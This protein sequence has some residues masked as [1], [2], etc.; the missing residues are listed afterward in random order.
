MG[1][2]E[3]RVPLKGEMYYEV[4]ADSAVEAKSKVDNHDDSA[5]EVDNQIWRSGKATNAIKQ[6]EN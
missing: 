4:E 6:P 5:K 3:V 1:V 2:Y